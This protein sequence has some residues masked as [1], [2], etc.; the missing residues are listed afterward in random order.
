MAL[1]EM[2]KTRSHTA[3]SSNRI[4]H[5]MSTGGWEQKV[6]SRAYIGRKAALSA[7]GCQPRQGTGQRRELNEGACLQWRQKASHRIDS[8]LASEHEMTDADQAGFAYL[9]RHPRAR[10]V[11]RFGKAPADA[12]LTSAEI[13]C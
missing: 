6:A 2:M 8:L 4:G 12:G 7:P 11:T 9:V 13:S 10:V 1:H 5:L 3:H